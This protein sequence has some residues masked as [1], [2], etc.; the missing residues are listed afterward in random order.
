M[1]KIFR[2]PPRS[3]GG[4]HITEAEWADREYPHLAA[5]RRD[6]PDAVV[7]KALE[8]YESLPGGSGR[9][10]RMRAAIHSVT[11]PRSS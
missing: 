4:A 10:E 7:S 5:A 6:I 11:R 3:P 8:A 2:K 1:P 9:H